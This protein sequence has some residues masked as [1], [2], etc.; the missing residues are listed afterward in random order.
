MRKMRIGAADFRIARH[1]GA[2]AS[3]SDRVLL[4]PLWGIWAPML[5]LLAVPHKCAVGY[6]QS[7]PAE[8][9]RR[10]RSNPGDTAGRRLGGPAASIAGYLPAAAASLSA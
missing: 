8:F 2:A 5:S 7:A 10:L 1:P 6:I 4:P 3:D 9:P